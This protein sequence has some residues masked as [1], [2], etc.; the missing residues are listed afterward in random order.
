MK[1]PIRLAA[2][3]TAAL[4]LAAAGSVGANAA[5]PIPVPPDDS[6]GLI[7]GQ[8]LPA[9]S[10]FKVEP[11]PA[12]SPIPDA[13][14][15]GLSRLSYVGALDAV[16]AVVWNTDDRV[17]EFYS[18]EDP[19]A[20]TAVLA[21]QLPLESVRVVPAVNSKKDVDAALAQIASVGGQLAADVRVE[22]AYAP[23]L[24]DE[25]VLSVAGDVDAAKAAATALLARSTATSIPVRVEESP[26]VSPTLRN[27]NSSIRFAGAY[28]RLPG[29][30]SCSTAFLIGEIGTSNR[31]MMS[32][33]HCGTG[34]S[35][36]WYY[37]T[38]TTA[39][40]QIS[41]YSGMLSWAPYTFDMGV[42]TGTTGASSF[43]AYVF[44]GDYLDVG[45]LSAVKGSASPVVNDQ[46]CYSGSY[47][48]NVCTNIVNYTNVLICYS[49]S[50][51]YQG[52]SITT[53]ASNI[54]AAGNG[55]SGGPVYT[56]TTGGVNA[57]GII[58][59]IVGGSSTC[60]GE[61][62]VSGGRQCSPVAIYAPI[63][64]GLNVNT[65]WGLYIIP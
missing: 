53:Q 11:S 9:D 44:T 27:V 50:M 19:A 49:I 42:W 38:S 47:S 48:G 35:G 52:Q 46:V 40:A 45:T 30:S 16:N 63:S 41:P 5:P 62:G 31:G 34:T 22:M 39:A 15:A 21:A 51:C 33:D 58:S 14:H 65:G 24:G 61:P 56:G 28:M 8:E 29:V 6:W 64:L 13:L 36:T 1:S 26:G 54:E 32:A 20:L 12:T 57:A 17:L 10:S 43:Y 3:V 2:A 4:L 18:A 60:T 59:G 25:L 23:P 55:D 37:S 7:A